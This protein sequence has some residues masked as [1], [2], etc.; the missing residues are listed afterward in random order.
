MATIVTPHTKQDVIKDDPDDNVILECALEGQVQHIIT[1]DK[2]LLKL[3]DFQ[4]VKIVTPSEF[5][6]N[7]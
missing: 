4:G 6:K 3:K 5:L 7:R 2:H 1:Q